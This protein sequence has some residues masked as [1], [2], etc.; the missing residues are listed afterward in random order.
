MQDEQGRKGV[1]LQFYLQGRRNRGI[2]QLDARYS[3]LNIYFHFR[4][5]ILVK[6]GVTAVALTLVRVGATLVSNNHL[7]SCH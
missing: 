3:T 7:S 2:A 1:R 6:I 5:I 4:M